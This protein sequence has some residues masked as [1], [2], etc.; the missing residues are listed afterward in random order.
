VVRV[1]RLVVIVLVAAHARRVRDVVVVV[2]VAICAGPRRHRMRIRQWP[3]R[4]RMVKRSIA[5]L[6]RVV[7]LFACRRE[8]RVRMIHWRQR[9][10]VIVL[11]ATYARCIR[12]VVVVVDVAVAALARGNCV[13]IRQRESSL[14]VI[15]VRRGPSVRGVAHLAGRWDSLLRVVRIIRVLI[16]RHVARNARRIGDVVVVVLVA[17]CAGPRRHRMLPG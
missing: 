13:R 8:M 3:S 11:M 16:I 5:P 17:I 1:L 7:A 9:L 14:R 15:E 2:D 10:V 12:D 6:I 4:R